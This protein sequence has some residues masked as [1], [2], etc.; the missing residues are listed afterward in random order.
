LL[1][2]VR[3]FPRPFWILMAGVFVNRFGT[4]VIPF[5]TLYL[6]DL[7]FPARAAGLALAAYGAGH[8]LASLA[9]QGHTKSAFGML[10]S[11]NGALIVLVELPLTRFTSQFPVRPTLALG[12][13][14][15]GLGFSLVGW[16]VALPWLMVAVGVFTLGEMLSMPVAAAY[17]AGLAPEHLRGRYLGLYGLSWATALVL[18]PALGV[19]VFGANPSA[20]WLGCGFLGV[21]A[22]WIIRPSR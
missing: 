15:I 17:V 19:A 12:Y 9:S 2:T 5:L 1:A 6:R 22:A 18:G 21:A 8:L 14:L 10:L 20:L 7:G 16:A 4:F 11:L 3:T 13:L